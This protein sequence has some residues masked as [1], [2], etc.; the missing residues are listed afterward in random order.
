MSRYSYDRNRDESES[1]Q[2]KR[3]PGAVII[4]VIAA[5]GII[6]ILLYT[7]IIGKTTFT[8]WDV[9]ETI[10]N[11]SD[12]KCYR[13]DNGYVLYNKDGAE[14][15][16]A[17]GKVIWK[18]SYNMT[19]PIGTSCGDYSA[20]ADRGGQEV[21]VTDGNGSS[22]FIHVPD[23]IVQVCVSEQGVTAIRTDAEESDHIYLY[24]S[25]GDPLLDIK[26][27]VRVSGFPVTMALSPDG[28]KLVTSYIK[29]GEEQENWITFYN[30][31]EV[32]QNYVDKVVGSYLYEDGIAPDIRFVNNERVT[33]TGRD[34]FV[35][36]KFREVPETGTKV[37]VSG[38][39][40]SI[41]SSQSRIAVVVKRAQGE[42]T[43]NIYN[44]D[45]SKLD[46]IITGM[47]I[48][49]IELTGEE[50]ILVCD[51][52]C[53]IYDKKGREKLRTRAD[54]NI[55]I[56]FS[57]NSGAKYTIVGNSTT[58]VIRLKAKSE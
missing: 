56:M 47:D 25:K 31:G 10:A 14:G 30:F 17:Q 45:G 22:T 20:F 8:S 38:E 19:S 4:M 55:R 49:R 13:T 58:K 12:A 50:T 35:V 34:G 5:F 18:V 46:E 11:I 54:E 28:T 52:S 3:N 51:D 15:H 36:Y 53:V 41:S 26:T 24:N 9:V 40:T 33:I 39:V 43:I 21:N 57:H 1:S 27:E 37:T 48:D 2:H 16:N 7:Y 44:S 32:G 42:Y 23:K 6:V 29:V